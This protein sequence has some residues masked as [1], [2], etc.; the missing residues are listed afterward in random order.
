MCTHTCHICACTRKCEFSSVY[1]CA[2][3][4]VGT[5]VRSSASQALFSPHSLFAPPQVALPLPVPCAKCCRG[6][7]RGQEG[8][9]SPPRTQKLGTCPAASQRGRRG[10]PGGWGL[11][12]PLPS[13]PA[14][15]P[16]CARV[17]V[18]KQDFSISLNPQRDSL[19]PSVP[20]VRRS[21]LFVSVVNSQHHQK[22]QFR[23][24]SPAASPVAPCS[25]GD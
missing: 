16:M 15:L 10:A 3:V 18:G 19:L 25:P 20:P 7:R 1:L 23:P 6:G 13:S 24:I 14:P 4:H 21:Q 12:R 8:P 17:P 2:C 22:I 5:R 11:H 9:P